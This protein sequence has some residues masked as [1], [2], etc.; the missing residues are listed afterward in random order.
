[1][2][3]A[4]KHCRHRCTNAAHFGLDYALPHKKMKR[5]S[6][7]RTSGFLLRSAPF[8]KYHQGFE[9]TM[10][11]NYKTSSFNCSSIVDIS[12][13]KIDELYN[14][15][16][17][18]R[19]LL[20][21]NEAIIKVLNNTLKMV[22]KDPS[23]VDNE[24]VNQSFLF[25]KEFTKYLKEQNDAD[26]MEKLMLVNI[27]LFKI[28]IL[29]N[30]T[31]TIQSQYNHL[32][33][34]RGA[35]ERVF[36]SKG[37][38]IYIMR[39]YKMCT[40]RRPVFYNMGISLYRDILMNRPNSLF[41]IELF[42]TIFKFME[43]ETL[44][45]DLKPL[46]ERFQHIDLQPNL[47]IYYS[48]IQNLYN[49]RVSKLIYPFFNLIKDTYGEELF[50]Q[51]NWA[52]YSREMY[53]LSFSLDID[54]IPYNLANN[55]EIML[56]DV[57]G[58]EAGFVIDHPL[59]LKSIAR[60][61]KSIG[62]LELLPF[63]FGEIIRSKRLNQMSIRLILE[64]M[65]HDLKLF[66]NTQLD[67]NLDYYDIFEVA[68]DLVTMSGI[69]Q[70]VEVQNYLL[71]YCLRE[72]RFDRVESIYHHI[73]KLNDETLVTMFNI[74]EKTGNFVE[75][76]LLMRRAKTEEYQFTKEVVA[77]YFKAMI[78]AKRDCLDEFIQFTHTYTFVRLGDGVFKFIYH[79]LN[80]I[81]QG[82]NKET[83]NRIK[84]IMED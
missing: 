33:Q 19:S 64:Y 6:F 76:N 1:M 43:K 57:G 78:A 22:E 47:Q 42:E 71:Y 14:H 53:A 60:A 26:M 51:E 29:G 23:K 59:V 65:D 77:A 82:L 80:N 70:V 56:K 36:K 41:T 75:A 40:E 12:S 8:P 83:D 2:W 49:N 3:V 68:H 52:K 73:D 10:M 62:R 63:L 4:Q 31:N 61:L 20:E 9:M 55:L 32:K 11:K 5:L 54:V 30:A 7:L 50:T 45:D 15:V 18:S 44:Y 38:E 46:F 16:K 79:E 74:Y 58:V 69:D 39:L 34:Q 13:L 48:I 24:L 67:K 37:N 35:L 25:C 84:S 17:Q 66:G 21:H 27:Y 81:K 28:S 72:N